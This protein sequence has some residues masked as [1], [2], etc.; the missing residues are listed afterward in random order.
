MEKKE[1]EDMEY[2]EQLLS[3]ADFSKETDLMARLKNALFTPV[4]G[5]SLDDLMK[6]S[7]VANTHDNAS[8]RPSRSAARVREDRMERRPPKK[9]GPRM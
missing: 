6:K 7:G 5:I 4:R 9:E 8:R 2:V 1:G 3:R